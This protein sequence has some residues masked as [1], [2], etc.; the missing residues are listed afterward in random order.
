MVNARSLSVDGRLKVFL[1]AGEASGD[2]Y[3]AAALKALRAECAKRGW[4][5]DAVGW[6]GD[7]MA[8]EGMRLLKHYR[9]MS[10]M[11]F[12][13]VAKHL[14]TI[15]RNLQRAHQDV[16]RE[17][18]DILLT[19]DFPGFNM[20]LAKALTQAKHPALRVQ[21]VAPQVWAWKPGRAKQLARDFDAVAP[22]LPFEQEALERAGV[23]VWPCGHPLL[24]VL[25][26]NQ[27]NQGRSI[28]LALLPGSRAQELRSLLPVLVEAAEKGAAKGWWSL[29]QVVVAGAPGR[30]RRDYV[31]AEN[32][33][34]KVVF[35][36][37]Q[38]VLRD[39]KQAWVASGTATL[40][41][42]LLNTPMVVVYRTSELTYRLAKRLARVNFIS[43]P[44][45]LLD[46]ACVP[47]LIQH[48]CTAARLLEATEKGLEG[49]L[50]GFDELRNALGE[51]GAAQ[52]LAQRV[53]KVFGEGSEPHH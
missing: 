35:G 15:L 8:A 52:T 4:E 18:P 30:T 24:D 26:S 32:A 13:E 9:T 2:A 27:P 12:W 7:L 16:Q 33:G 31:L 25:A 48:A 46:R 10:F 39:A 36:Q 29:D 5:L 1:V 41:A 45:L 23:A 21:W 51:S 38:N 50:K 37:T 44:N 43:L 47:E 34:I 11:G 17:A 3:G 40:E 53:A 22:I 49:Q 6:G 14:P 28:A 19:L 42:A 20:R